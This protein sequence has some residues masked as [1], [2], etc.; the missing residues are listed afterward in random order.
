MNLSPADPRDRL[1][2][3]HPP[4]LDRAA[5]GR[6][7]PVD[8]TFLIGGEERDHPSDP[9]ERIEPW[10]NCR[11]AVAPVFADQ[12][13]ESQVETIQSSRRITD[14]ASVIEGVLSRGVIIHSST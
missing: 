5:N 1:L 9:T 14:S 3:P 8:A 12:L 6:I 11:C 2:P 13:A 7:V 10:A 4:V